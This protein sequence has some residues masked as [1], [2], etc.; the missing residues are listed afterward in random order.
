MSHEDMKNFFGN[1]FKMF[2]DSSFIGNSFFD[3][4]GQMFPDRFGIFSDSTLMKNFGS[5]EFRS[6]KFNSDS[7][8]ENFPDFDD[9]FGFSM[10]DKNDSI[11]GK[12][13]KGPFV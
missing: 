1:H 11:S 10:Q 6:F 13:K 4:F 7:S 9:F 2:D 12:N 3:N 5:K 8:V